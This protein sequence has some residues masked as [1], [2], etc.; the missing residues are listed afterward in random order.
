MLPRDPSLKKTPE[1]TDLEVIGVLCKSFR[2]R[3]VRGAEALSQSAS[4]SEQEM[5]K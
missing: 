4:V 3:Q 2:G 1:F 5:R